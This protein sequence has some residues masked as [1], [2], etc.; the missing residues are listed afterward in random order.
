[1]SSAA[2]VRMDGGQIAERPAF[3]LGEIKSIGE[4]FAKSGYFRDAKDASQAI[5]KIMAGAEL[6]IGPMASM[7]GIHIVEGKPTLSANLLAAAVRRSGRYNYKVLELTAKA[8]RIEFFEG[9]ESIGI[10]ELT[11]EE[12]SAAKLNQSWDREKSAWKDKATWKS[13][14][15]NMLFARTM[16][17]GVKFFCPEVTCGPC[18]TPDEL[19]VESDENGEIITSS[20]V[21]N[22]KPVEVIT[23]PRQELCENLKAMW[24]QGRIELFDQ[25]WSIQDDKTVDQIK[26]WF[27]GLT[28][29]QI[30]NEMV[31]RANVLEREAQLTA[32]ATG[33]QSEPTREHVL[34]EIEAQIAKLDKAMGPTSATNLVMKHTQG[35]EYDTFD[36]QA[37]QSLSADLAND[38][39]ELGVE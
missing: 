24:P 37:L 19:D 2:L 17:N 14:P 23:D 31:K 27:K 11:M 26:A 34:G 21:A 33:Q 25:W 1:M 9:K 20:R 10:S 38:L 35:E 7:A 8:C 36:L 12:A 5:V 16:S 29:A 18:Y 28:V 30:R 39:T 3:D 4:I 6:G 22:I 13:F 15:K 32:E